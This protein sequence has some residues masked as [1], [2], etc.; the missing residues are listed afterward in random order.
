MFSQYNMIASS[1]R[2]PSSQRQVLA[3]HMIGVPDEPRCCRRANDRQRAGRSGSTNLG[4]LPTVGGGGGD[5]RRTRSHGSSA[6]LGWHL[7]P[8]VEQRALPLGS[9][10]AQDGT[11]EFA[12]ALDVLAGHGPAR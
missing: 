2:S 6:G 11:G 1:G 10:Q 3:A 7:M 4:A 8:G 9:S 5:R 12:R